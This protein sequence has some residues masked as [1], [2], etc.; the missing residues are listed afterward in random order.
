LKSGK[1]SIIQEN[2][3]P[4]FYDEKEKNDSGEMFKKT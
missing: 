3:F 4:V 2:F 1:K